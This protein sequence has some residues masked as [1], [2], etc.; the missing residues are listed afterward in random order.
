V[1]ESSSRNPAVGEPSAAAGWKIA[2]A[3]R[4]SP[5]FG[6]NGMRLA[7]DGWLYVTQV[8]GSQITAINPVTGE[9]KIISPRGGAIVSPDDLDFDS[10]GVMYVTEYLNSRVV[11]RLPNGEV[12]VVSDQV[13]GANGITVHKDRLFIDECRTG[14]RLLELFHDGRA[15]RVMAD[16]LAMPNACAV[17]PDGL[18]YFPEVLSGDIW[19]MPLDGGQRER[20]I[21]GM[22]TPPA[23][24]FDNRGALMV[25]ESHTGDVTR[26]DLQSR[27]KTRVATIETGLD[28]FVIAPDDRIFVSSFAHGSVWEIASNGRRRRARAD[29][30]GRR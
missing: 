9:K 24:K 8:F 3:V 15:P 16:G 22:A 10:N 23:V 19:R 21:G 1:A 20:F 2:R 13:P 4:P 7:P 30:L 12:R 6:S 5:L 18:L 14:G 26:I 17:G 11:A 27:R 28:N 25:L 29:S